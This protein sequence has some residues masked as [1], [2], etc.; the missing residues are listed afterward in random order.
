M[1]ANVFRLACAA[2]ALQVAFPGASLAGEAAI[3][4][5]QSGEDRWVPSL[6]ITAGATIQDQQGFVNSVRYSPPTNPTAVPLQG[7]F[8]G[9]DLAASPFVGGGLELMTPALPI[10]LRPRLFLGGEILPTFAGD[11]NL[12]VDKRPGCL[13]GPEVNAPCVNEI[14]GLLSR[15]FS[16]DALIGQGSVTTATVDTLVFGA[17]IGVAFPARVYN[18]QIRIKPSA[19]WISYEVDAEGTVVDGACGLYPPQVGINPSKCIPIDIDPQGALRE[20]VLMGSGS[21]RFHGIGGGLDLEMDTIRY[22]PLGVSLFVGARAYRI[23]GDRSIDFTA[24]QTFGV[25]FDSQVPP[26]AIFPAETSV[27]TWSVEVDPWMYRAH[28]G[29]RIHWLGSGN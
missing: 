13:K 19:G 12:A 20:T 4:V 10:P 23:L 1:G 28:V 24:S 16:E 5:G 29:I 18:R 9:D 27:A 22:G 7:A 15:S 25:G 3:P 21:Q 6:S 2:V 17:S 14:E 11:R 8:S 26:V